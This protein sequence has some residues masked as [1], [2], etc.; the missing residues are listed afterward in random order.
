MHNRKEEPCAALKGDLSPQQIKMKDQKH[1]QKKHMKQVIPVTLTGKTISNSHYL[2][3]KY[4]AQEYLQWHL[5]LVL[6]S[7]F[8]LQM[9]A[10]DLGTST[11]YWH[12]V[13]DICG[14]LNPVRG[15]F[16]VAPNPVCVIC[17]VINIVASQ[18]SII[19][20]ICTYFAASYV[21]CL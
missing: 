16:V 2:W 10:Y 7:V 6:K 11:Y 1:S 21:M 5:I 4:W 18:V 19:L 8:A 15:C 14:N 3:V 9:G 20:G 13:L 12:M 17:C